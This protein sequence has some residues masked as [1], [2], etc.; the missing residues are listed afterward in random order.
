MV[1]KT[2]GSGEI[3]RGPNSQFGKPGKVLEKK[4]RKGYSQFERYFGKSTHSSRKE[5]GTHSLK[6]TA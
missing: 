2:Y 3:L 4:Q 5:K 1:C 6:G